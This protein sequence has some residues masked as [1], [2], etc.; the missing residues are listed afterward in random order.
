MSDH[1]RSRRHKNGA[2]PCACC[3]DNG[4]ELR[5]A[6]FLEVVREVHDQD[7]ILGHQT[8]E[9]DQSH[10]AVD[11]E[12]RES[13]KREQKRS[14][15]RQR[16]RTEKNDEWIAETLKLSGEHQIDQNRRE[17]KGTEKTAAFSPELTRF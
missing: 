5:F 16:Y 14:G 17:Q 12:C 15:N 7:P 6:C 13:K 10:L 4:V 9:C 1:G 2:K 3:V 11:V 8:D